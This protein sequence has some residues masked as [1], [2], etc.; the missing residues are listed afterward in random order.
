MLKIE[1]EREKTM[2][3]TL[4]TLKSEIRLCESELDSTNKELRKAPKGYMVRRKVSDKYYYCQK[5]NDGDR[6]ITNESSIIK[7]LCRKKYLTELRMILR[8]NI[9]L[10]MDIMP[11]I[12]KG[13]PEEI[14]DS[15]PSSYQDFPLEFFLDSEI[16]DEWET[17]EFEQNQKYP[18][19][20]IHPTNKGIMVRSK[21]EQLIGNALEARHIPYR[22]EWI[23]QIEGKEFSPDFAVMR[24]SDGKVIF[25]EHFGMVNVEHYTRTMEYKLSHYRAAGITLWENLIITFEDEKGSVDILTINKLIELFLT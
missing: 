23:Q 14:I 24:K 2:N 22:Y 17:D 6:G 19:N 11:I 5:K 7:K 18:E 21:G 13:D 8:I 4:E 15:L 20:K 1:G 12:S 3:R 25:W 16:F 10:L 9:E